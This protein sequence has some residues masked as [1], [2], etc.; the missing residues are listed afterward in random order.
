[1]GLFNGFEVGEKSANMVESQ[2]STALAFRVFQAAGSGSKLMMLSARSYR[3]A[4]RSK[5]S[6]GL[7]TAAVFVAG[8]GPG[9]TKS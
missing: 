7:T 2:L 1:M 6:V 9:F 3:K 4:T 5:S 8:V